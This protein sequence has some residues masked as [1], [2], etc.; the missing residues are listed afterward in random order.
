MSVKA[1]DVIFGDCDLCVAAFTRAIKA[2]ATGTHAAHSYAPSVHEVRRSPHPLPR[3]AC[4]A[5]LAMPHLPSLSLHLTAVPG[6]RGA[7]LLAPEVRGRA[8]RGG[9]DGRGSRV[10][11]CRCSRARRGAAGAAGVCL[12]H[13]SGEPPA[14]AAGAGAPMYATHG[15]GPAAGECHGRGQAAPHPPPTQADSM[16]LLDR[17]H[18][19]MAFADMVIA[20]RTRA[21]ES[22]ADFAC[23][24]RCPPP[25]APR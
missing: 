7:P 16:L 13:A 25:Q 18:Q 1:T 6:L 15:C 12:R 14:P 5:P 20:V 2:H 9:G 10:G 19:A 17:H 11:A 22:V 8:A 4:G 23:D 21:G 3:K 24:V